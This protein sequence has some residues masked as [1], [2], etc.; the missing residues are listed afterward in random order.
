ML[1]T[2]R[3][4]LLDFFDKENGQVGI[5]DA[6]NPTS[7]HRRG[8]KRTMEEHGIQTIFV[9]SS[10]DDQELIEQN[11]RNVKISSPDVHPKPSATSP[12]PL[13]HSF[14]SSSVV[15]VNW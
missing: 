4:D 14:I 11:V 5:Y 6:V 7:V 10:C 8:W 13:R 9:E 3:N 12:R 15:K 1:E 2:C